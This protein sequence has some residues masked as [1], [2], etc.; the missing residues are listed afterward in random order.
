MNVNEPITAIR[1]IGDS[2]ANSLKKMKVYTIGDILFSFPRTYYIYKEPIKEEDLSK[3][4][5]EKI[6]ITLELRSNAMLKK[7]KRF[8]ISVV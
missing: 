7:T 3:H 2:K 6:A 1:G 4:V 8:D 5:G